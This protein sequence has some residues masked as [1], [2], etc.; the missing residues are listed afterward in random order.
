[1]Q[2][3]TVKKIARDKQAWSGASSHERADEIK[4][5]VGAVGEKTIA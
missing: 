3:E 4:D 2:V 5:G 1:V